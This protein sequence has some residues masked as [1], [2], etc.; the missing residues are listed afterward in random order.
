MSVE[1]ILFDLDGTLLDTL[2]DIAG[3]MNRVLRQR[4]YPVHDLEAYRY[5]VGNGSRKLVSRVLPESKRT[6]EDV[7][8]CLK[9]FLSAYGQHWVE[10]TRP[11]EG[12]PAML[13]GLVELGFRI[14][15][16]SNKTDEMTKK[17]VGRLLSRWTFDA[18]VGQREDVP[19]KPDPTA[20][21]GIAAKLKVSPGDCIYVGDSGVDMMTAASAG[22]YAIGV[23]WGFRTAG[24][25]LQ[26]GAKALIARPKDL[27]EFL[28]KMRLCDG[29]GCHA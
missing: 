5:F 19:V 20:A 6:G 25:L 14:A 18:V 3:A 4:G 23:L 2:E 10:R 16:L 9:A 12:V 24:E 27:L 28:H 8:S 22:M 29:K 13:D 1:A 15:V 26:N 21:L 7:D 17:L 11:Y